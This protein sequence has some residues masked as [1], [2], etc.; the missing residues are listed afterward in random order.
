MSSDNYKARRGESDD[1]PQGCGLR[2]AGCG[3]RAAGCGPASVGDSDDEEFC[4][5]IAG[6]LKEIGSRPFLICG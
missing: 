4:A 6:T 1:E 2:A 5:T 3:L